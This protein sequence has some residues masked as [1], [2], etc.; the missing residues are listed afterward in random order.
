VGEE[1]KNDYRMEGED[2]AMLCSC[3][4]PNCRGSVDLEHP[5]RAPLVHHKAY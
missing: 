4:A 5:T 3:G 1:R 2:T